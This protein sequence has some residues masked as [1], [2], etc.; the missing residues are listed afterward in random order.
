M[1]TYHQLFITPFETVG[2][3]VEL[4]RQLLEVSQ[5]ILANGSYG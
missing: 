2:E 1:D 5:S 4:I 3:V